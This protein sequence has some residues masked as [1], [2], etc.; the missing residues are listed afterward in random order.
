MHHPAS[1]QA[2]T[3]TS[4]QPYGLE[5]TGHISNPSQM[6]TPSSMI[7]AGNKSKPNIASCTNI[8]IQRMH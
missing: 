3:E 4:P 7:M 2:N 6:M 8:F 1:K 5:N